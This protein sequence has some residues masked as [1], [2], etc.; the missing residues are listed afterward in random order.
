MGCCNE[1]QHTLPTCNAPNSQFDMNILFNYGIYPTL[2][3]IQI[4]LALRQKATVVLLALPQKA[5]LPHKNVPVQNERAEQP[6]MDKTATTQ[7]RGG[8]KRISINSCLPSVLL[9][10]CVCVFALVGVL[11]CVCLRV[12]PAATLLCK[13]VCTHLHTEAV[14]VCVTHTYTTVVGF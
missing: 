4:F 12:W 9:C 14:C 1:T 8:Q 7:A 13:C 10:V 3:L 5:L 11:V 6:K 2:Y